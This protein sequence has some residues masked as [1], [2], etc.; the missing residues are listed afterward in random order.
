MV[1]KNIGQKAFAG[2][3]W[4]F[5][6]RII[7]Q[8]VSL[9]V[10]III[11]R[12][13]DPND[14]SVVSIVAIFFAFANVFIS[15]GLNTALVQ[16]KNADGEDYSAVL[17]LSLITAVLIYFV[18]F[19]MAPVIAKLYEQDILV[20]IIRVMSL[21]LPVN[22]I[23]SVLCAKISSDLA[24]KKFFFATIGGTA[25]SAIIGISMAVNGFGAWSLVAQQMSNIVIDT[26]ILSLITKLHLVFKIS[27]PRV[28][29]L[30]GYG[31]KVFVS[32]LIGVAYTEIV[33]SVIGIKYDAS[34]LSYYTKGRS[35][36]VLISS[37]TTST[38]S[39]VLFPMLSKYQ[40]D[41]DRL[42]EYTRFFIRMSSF[43][44]FPVMLGFVAVSDSFVLLLLTEKWL[45][46]SPY[47]KIFCIAY[48]FDMIHIGNCETIKAM[49][50]SDIYL[51]M[52]II[53]KSAY[54]VT[55]A[56]FMLLSNSP[57]VLSFAF[58]VC[59]CIAT[60]V[61]SF[62]NKKLI[63]YTY[64]NQFADLFPNLLTSIILFFVVHA[65]NC[66]SV[67]TWIKLFIQIFVGFVTYLVL[68]LLI[69]NK[70]LMYILDV[71][72]P[73]YIKCFKKRGGN[74]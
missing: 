28:K 68:N 47:I 7:A 62:P 60:V 44:A 56:T 10:S 12:I 2:V 71:L 40:D 23:K 17:F 5:S 61:N 51:I 66:L 58:I 20:P 9:I 72:K 35:F 14:Y 36:P 16:K 11:A 24:F 21:T 6:E 70:S 45:P 31:W 19:F 3:I 22:A 15:G 49:G 64:K 74:T 54:F 30:F 13:L 41:K 29:S 26:L 33:P 69:K 25:I 32:S 42:L 18:L 63:G 65:M 48:M 55:I 38:F 27:L 34:D 73:I 37:T 50:R 46:A 57:I 39:A 52:E 59:T 8:L 4:K 1:E 43:V 67:D 53:K